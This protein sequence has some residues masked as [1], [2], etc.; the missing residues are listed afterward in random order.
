VDG[1]QF[2]LLY[3]GECPLCLREVRF[4]Q[5]RDRGRIWFVDIA[6]PEYDPALHGGIDFATAMGRIHGILPDGTVLRD[7][8]VFRQVYALI[9]LGWVYGWTQWPGFRPLADWA[10]GFWA[11]RRLAWTGRP[12]LKTL[13]TQRCQGRC[14]PTPQRP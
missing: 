13:T 9:G 5:R 7:M 8:A 4:L 3:D 14:T 12:D 1:W 2:K 11:A 6:A 10:Y